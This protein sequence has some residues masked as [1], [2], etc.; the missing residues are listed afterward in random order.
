[1]TIEEMR[2]RKIELGFSNKTLSIR[3]GVPV[4]TLQKIFSG[5][6]TAPREETVKALEKA[7]RPPVSYQIPADGI[8]MVQ[9]SSPAYI[10]N[11]KYSVRDYLALPGDKR[12]ELIDGTFYDMASPSSIHQNIA[13]YIYRKLCEF[14]ESKDGKCRP[15]IGPLDV[16]LDK[17]EWTIVQPDIMIVCDRKKITRE[18]IYGAPDFVLEI[19]S[20]SSR[21]KD[22]T[23]KLWKYSNAGVREY[24]ILDPEENSVL[25]YDLTQGIQPHRFQQSDSV[26][27][28]IWNSECHIVL[29]DVFQYVDFLYN[30]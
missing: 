8:S 6:T 22:M 24:W 18:G 1:M 14:V 10:A 28:L 16:Q 25:Q 5:K 13:G 2:K 30:G 19:L 12:M 9:D 27:V 15:M 17:D 20:T 23:L 21:K 26:P 7:L 4:G 11:R 29:A 3:S